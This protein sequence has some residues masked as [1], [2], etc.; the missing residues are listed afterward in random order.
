[1]LTWT[2]LVVIVV[3][4]GSFLLLFVVPYFIAKMQPALPVDCG[5]INAPHAKRLAK[6][7]IKRLWRTYFYH[8]D[9]HSRHTQSFTF[10]CL[11][12]N[13]VSDVEIVRDLA[14]IFIMLG[15]MAHAW[16][17]WGHAVSQK[18]ADHEREQWE[19]HLEDIK[20]MQRSTT[21]INQSH[22]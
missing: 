8:S 6:Q 4:G 17:G 13:A 7:H 14:S 12:S 15:V 10:I 20:A 2:G 22:V 19:K 21:Q 5:D 11:L 1:M 9:R 16:Y 18:R 3:L